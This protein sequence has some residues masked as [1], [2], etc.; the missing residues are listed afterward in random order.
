MAK[1][2]ETSVW[3]GLIFLIYALQFYNWNGRY[4]DTDS[5]LYALRV[6]EWLQHPTWF[7]QKFLMANYPFG[8]IKHWTRLMDVIITICSMPFLLF[9]PIKQA[10]FHGSLLLTPLLLVLTVLYL[11]T[12][13]DKI[14]NLYGRI[15]LFFLLYVQDCFIKIFAFN[16][17]DHHA[18][19]IFLAVLLLWQLYQYIRLRNEK[20]LIWAGGVC[21]V[22]IWTAV[23]GIIPYG[24]TLAF[25]YS[26]YLFFGYS[27]VAI[28]KFALSCAV[29]LTVFWLINPPFQGWLYADNGRL[30]VIYVMSAWYA[31]ITIWLTAKI[32][33]AYI[34]F[35]GLAVAV[36]ILAVI[37]WCGG[38]LSSPLS[39]DIKE[40]FVNRIYEM[41]SGF[42]PYKIAYPLIALCLWLVLWH[43]KSDRELLFLLAI[44]AGGYLVL[45]FWAMRFCC[46]EAIY[47]T[48]IIAYWVAGLNLK[49]ISFAFLL[50]GLLA[51]EFIAFTVNAALQ[52]DLTRPMT[53]NKVFNINV[54]AK[55]PLK[56]GSVVTDVFTTPYVMWYANRPTVASPYHTN[57]EG[58]RDNHDI[59]FS[60]NEEKVLQLLLK[61]QVKTIILPYQLNDKEYYAEPEQN[62]DK[63]YGKIWGCRN[64]PQWLIAKDINER[65]NYM[66]F[67][68][69]EEQV[70]NLL[71]QMQ[72]NRVN[73]GKQNLTEQ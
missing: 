50:L 73:N 39:A 10:V 23:E 67:E 35:G 13:G 44:F 5:Y 58:I 22:F 11:K 1:K 19:H 51:V 30:S 7:E 29:C 4:M 40:A 24:L 28:R 37:L 20:S 25:L 15:V 64:Y 32:K 48:L 56:E 70:N 46:F 55:Y 9:E 65:E 47:T 41:D 62:C 16:R 38:C 31:Y 72:H 42:N 52:Y 26:G 18:V 3:I 21:A 54:F 61:H 60:N 69:D 6:I 36:G 49:K 2:I 66:I 17:P 45:S 68:I 27:Y 34:Q 43:K 12:L 71:E 57:I 8:E 59:M 14:L 63:L 33:S 53:G